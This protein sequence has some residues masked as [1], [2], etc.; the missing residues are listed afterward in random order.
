[1]PENEND[2]YNLHYIIDE[3]QPVKKI[4]IRG[5][6]NER[7]CTEKEESNESICL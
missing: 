6:I 7:I 4:K 5:E 1:M 3:N 2:V